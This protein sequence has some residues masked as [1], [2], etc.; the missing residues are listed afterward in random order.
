V[1]STSRFF[2]YRSNFESTRPQSNREFD[3]E[4]SPSERPFEP[5]TTRRNVRG[6]YRGRTFRNYSDRESGEGGQE[7][8]RANRR[9]Y[10]RQPRSFV[11]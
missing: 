4:D 9:Q 7:D 5:D 3:Q 1:R 2:F 11:T 8:Y 6:N 10:D